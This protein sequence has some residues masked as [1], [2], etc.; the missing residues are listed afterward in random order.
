MRSKLFNDRPETTQT[1]SE[2][3]VRIFPDSGEGHR[4]YDPLAEK[5]LGRILFDA[6]DNWIYDGQLLNV[7]EQED[8]A[9]F[10]TGHRQE[11]ELLMK[12]L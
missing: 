12:D 1:G 11:M 5:E 9:G 2:R 7:Y 4:L 6:A 8:V 10:I 3:W